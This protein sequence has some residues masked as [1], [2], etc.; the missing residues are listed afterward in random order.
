[1]GQLWVENMMIL[2]EADHVMASVPD[3]IV[4]AGGRLPH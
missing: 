3:D 1:V 4:P 2:R